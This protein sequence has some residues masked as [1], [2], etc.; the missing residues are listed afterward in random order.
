MKTTLR[1]F[2]LA[3]LAGMVLAIAAMLI[4]WAP[5]KP[6][7]QLLKRWAAPPSQ[8]VDLG[9]MQVHVR[10]EGP[11]DD[12]LPIFLLHGTSASL[13]TWDGWADALK[14]KHRVIRF[15]LPG[16]G[17]TGPKPESD[18]DYSIDAYVRF[19]GAMADRLGVQRF[20]LA[21]NSLGGQIAWTT[22]YAM[23][24]RVAKL[25][26]VNAGGYPLRSGLMDSGGYPVNPTAMPIGFRLARTP[27]VRTL[28]KHFLPRIIV[29]EGLRSAYGD[30]E[31]ITP[32][33]IDRYTDMAQ[34]AGNRVAL[35]RRFEYPL[36]GDIAPIK[37]LKQ[38]TLILWGAK[39]G[40][41]PLE[42][43]RQFE[44]DIANSELVTFDALGH[45][46]QEEGPDQTAAAVMR[47][48]ENE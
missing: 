47:F 33:L 5:D 46:P 42:N 13:H 14:D 25:V 48:L 17:L 3:L 20:V 4:T 31:K 26:L 10:D 19:V 35:A 32:A 12:P 11:R 18:Q 23:P 24:L 6:V 1:L 8:F 27:V 45:V 44:T 40:M 7:E 9:G 2:G 39:D 15:D 21:G 16:F 34:R 36:S 30:P 29:Q 43:G 28:M 38:K 37:T 41:L 22:A